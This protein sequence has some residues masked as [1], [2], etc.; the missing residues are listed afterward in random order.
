MATKNEASK[1]LC[2]RSAA[3]YLPESLKTVTCYYISCC[4][5]EYILHKYINIIA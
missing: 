5:Y 4:F 3:I 1:M 2:C